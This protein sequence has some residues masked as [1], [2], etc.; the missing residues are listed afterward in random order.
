M[1]RLLIAERAPDS[2]RVLV[3]GAG[4][5]QELKEFA[6]AHAG[7][8]FDGVDPSAEM[9][10]L[11]QQT[12]GSLASRARLH[13]GYIDAAPKGPFDAASCLLTMHFM[14]LEERRR[15][16][17]EVRRRLKS[18]APFVVAHFSV[19]QGDSEHAIWLCRYTAFALASGVDPTSAANA[20]AAIDTHVHILS[21]QQDE[22]IFARSRLLAR[23]SVLCRVHLP[24]LGGIRVTIRV[25]RPFRPTRATRR[26][27]I[28]HR[29]PQA[30][31]SR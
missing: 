23:E 10:H 11:A 6:Q 31:R 29:F 7:W 3:L 26:R 2:A 30:A 28:P 25:K 12:M 1:T 15:A 18:G 22:A 4:G 13:Q 5:G 27:R 16:T 9:L 19:P 8:S 21:P 14:A 20:R 17:A 24:R